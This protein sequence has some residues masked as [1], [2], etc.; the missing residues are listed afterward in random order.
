LRKEHFSSELVFLPQLA[1]LLGEFFEGCL[2]GVDIGRTKCRFHFA[3]SVSLV[4]YSSTDHFALLCLPLLVGLCSPCKNCPWNDQL[5]VASD[6]K[7]YSLTSCMY[8]LVSL[9]V[10][11][12]VMFWYCQSEIWT[13]QLLL[14]CVQ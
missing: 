6:F 4:L 1:W 5:C 3:A 10:V 8:G 12:F 9:W 13:P 2:E 11:E 14:I 7:P